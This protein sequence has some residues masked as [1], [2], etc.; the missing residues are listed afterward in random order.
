VWGNDQEYGLRVRQNIEQ[1][2]KVL[3]DDSEESVEDFRQAWQQL[4]G[5]E[6]RRFPEG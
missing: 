3:R 1:L 5:T 4:R 6:S 2:E